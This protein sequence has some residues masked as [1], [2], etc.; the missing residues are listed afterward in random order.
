MFAQH[1]LA[2]IDIET[3]GS[4]HLSDHITEIAIIYWQENQ[5]ELSIFQTLINPNVNIPY[6]IQKLTGID[7]QMLQS[8]PCFD[9][10]MA[11]KI[12]DILK[13]RI[14]IAH[15]ARF[16]Y[17]FIK[18]AFKRL[19]RS[20]HSNQLC[21]VKLSRQLFPQYKRHGLDQLIER[22]HLNTDQ[23]HRA[24]ADAQAIKQ[25]WQHIQTEFNEETIIAACKT[26]MQRPCLPPHLNNNLLNQIEDGYGVYLIYGENDLPLYIGKSKHVKTR[27]LSHFRQDIHNSKEMTLS[28][29]ARHIEVIACQGELDA[30]LTESRQIKLLQ[31]ILNRRLRRKRDLFSWQLQTDE[32]GY[33]YLTLISIDQKQF[34]AKERFYGLFHTKTEAKKALQNCLSTTNLCFQTLKL[35]KGQEGQPCFRHQL[36]QCSGACIKCIQAPLH[37]MQLAI[38][39][40]K[41]KIAD[42]PFSNKAY[43]QENHKY[44]L[45]DHWI[46]LGTAENEYELEQMITNPSGELD[47]DIYQI[48][49]QHQNKLQPLAEMNSKI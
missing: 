27:L 3:T 13:N 17:G 44:H 20:F 46:Y 1:Q 15:N 22:Y 7:N 33:D 49:R 5:T 34:Y 21:T 24:L 10:G 12:A 43:I 23:R 30:L 2:F 16:D 47:K 14:F 38:Q 35:E 29:Q 6:W 11:D 37:N 32:Y 31:P 48:I 41:F 39:L 45:F 26:I 4:R 42:W 28:Q 9:D 18:N 36:H 25:F 8:A 19:N 40:Q